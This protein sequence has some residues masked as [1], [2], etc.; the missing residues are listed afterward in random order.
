MSHVVEQLS[1]LVVGF[2]TEAQAADV[3]A[4]LEGCATCTAERRRLEE[5]LHALALDVDPIAP[6]PSLRS[7]I[8][9]A[10]EGER[11]AP[12]TARLAGLFDVA[13]DTAAAY[14][15]RLTDPDGWVDLLPGITYLDLEG[16]PAAAG[17]RV[18]LVRMDPGA[19]FPVHRHVGT[20][21]VFVLQGGIR[22]V[23][24]AEARAGAMVE[25]PDGSEHWF[26]ALGDEGLVYAVVVAD[27]QILGP[28]PL[29]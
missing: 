4:H 19:R 25:M 17:G 22:D 14:L 12:L 26:E 21:R 6:P 18:G 5:A 20:E 8:L 29:D 9:D 3:E 2:L 7:N 27:V 24:G 10:A 23:S 1:D 13:V 28:A 15:G 11:F 16:G